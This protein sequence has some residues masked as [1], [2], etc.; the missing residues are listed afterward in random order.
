MRKLIFVLMVCAVSL[1]ANAQ[2]LRQIAMVD[3]PG[4]PGFDHIVFANEFLVVSHTGANAVDVFDPAKRRVV[5]QISNIDQPRGMAVDARN[6]RIFLAAANA[7]IYVI[8]TQDW[9]VKD[10]F[11]VSGVPEELLLSPDG[12]ILYVADQVAPQVAAVDVSLRRAAATA[13]VGGRVG[14]IAMGDAGNL[15]VTVEDQALVVQF[16]SQMKTTA[17]YKLAASQPTGIIHDPAKKRLYVAVR[18]AVVELDAANGT[19]ITRIAAPRG[20]TSLWLDERSRM[21]FAGGGGSIVAMDTS[22]GS[23]QRQDEI[24]IDVRGEA[25]AFDS[26]RGLVYLPGGRE[27]RSKL[28][29]VR[30]SPRAQRSTSEPELANSK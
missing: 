26:S 7:T 6:N 10:S 2:R 23:L 17:R 20:V 30:H 29:I 25:L 18:S 5:A 9:E 16:D 14:G 15:F 19:E 8:S 28:L 1:A 4:R 13:D 11:T 12:R 22:T 24:R 27:G 3:L 21:L